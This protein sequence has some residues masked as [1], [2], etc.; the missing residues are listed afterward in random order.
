LQ[1]ESWENVMAKAGSYAYLPLERVVFGRSAAEV[2]PEEAVRI[3]GKR[4][5]IVAS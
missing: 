5:F 2:V 1:S 4:V 3:G